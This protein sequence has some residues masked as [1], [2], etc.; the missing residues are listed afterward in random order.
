[1]VDAVALLDLSLRVEPDREGHAELLDER[2]HVAAGI[3]VTVERAERRVHVDADDGESLRAEL[4]MQPLERGHLLHARRTPGPPHVEHHDA[5]AQRIQRGGAAVHRAS[6]ECRGTR[7][8]RE[9][10]DTAALGPADR[11]E[12][13][14]RAEDEAQEQPVAGALAHTRGV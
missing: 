8:G 11:D 2:R 6:L 1:A 13:S 12:R 5:A 3:A 4:A 10:P 9:R 7:A 14:D